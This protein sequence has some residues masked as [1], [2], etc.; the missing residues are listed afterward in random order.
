[1]IYVS[2]RREFWSSRKH[3]RSFLARRRTARYRHA[4]LIGSAIGRTNRRV[5]SDRRIVLR[6]SAVHRC[7]LGHQAAAR[8]AVTCGGCGRRR[9][10][11]G[12]ARRACTIGP[13][14]DVTLAR[15]GMRHT[16]WRD[17]AADRLESVGGYISRP[18]RRRAISRH[19]CCGSSCCC[20]LRASCSNAICSSRPP[21]RRGCREDSKDEHA[22][23]STSP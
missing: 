8:S 23:E 15:F 1:M 12:R 9:R 20:W 7:H 16:R 5:V 19:R 2:T 11:I 18:R 14:S 6:R 4:W 17:S 22:H 21:R 13:L 3:R 10:R